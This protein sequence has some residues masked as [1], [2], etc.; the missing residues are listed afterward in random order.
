MRR[1]FDTYSWTYLDVE[2]LIG[3]VINEMKFMRDVNGRLVHEYHNLTKV[4]QH[5]DKFHNI[6][7]DAQ[8]INSLPL[9][10]QKK[11]KASYKM[12]SNIY[13]NKAR[14]YKVYKG[15]NHTFIPIENKGVLLLRAVENL[16]RV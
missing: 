4:K 10:E 12:F 3:G 7:F 5:L 15:S 8:T 2:N 14:K 16:F 1:Q 11:A 9:D 6:K 13:K